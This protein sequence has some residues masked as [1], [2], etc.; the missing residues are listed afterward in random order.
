MPAKL[1]SELPEIAPEVSAEI[2]RFLGPPER[3]L[4]LRMAARSRIEAV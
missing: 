1:Q 2:A 4:G 3:V